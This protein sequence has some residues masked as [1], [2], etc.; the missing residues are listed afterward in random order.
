MTGLADSLIERIRKQHDLLQAMNDDHKS[1]SVEVVSQNEVVRVTVDASGALTGLWL[2]GE[3]QRMQ[4]SEL[5]QLIVETAQDATR[6]SL[7]RCR[8]LG[9]QFNQKFQ[10][11]QQEPLTKWDGTTFTPDQS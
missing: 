8:L 9:E 2:S 5:A 1:I 3:A 6:Q 7:E 11:L 10:E 4:S